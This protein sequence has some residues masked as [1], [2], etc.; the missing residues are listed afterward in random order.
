MITKTSMADEEIEADNCIIA[1]F[2]AAANCSADL[3]FLLANFLIE[4]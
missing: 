2:F 3:S 4:V 1:T